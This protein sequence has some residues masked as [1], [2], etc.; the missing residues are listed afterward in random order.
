MVV[1]DERDPI[2]IAQGLLDSR[3]PDHVGEQE[4]HQAGAV[5]APEFF[6]AGALFRCERQV[7]GVGQGIRTPGRGKPKPAALE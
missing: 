6:D 7:H 1:L 2:A 3:G 5:P 4:R